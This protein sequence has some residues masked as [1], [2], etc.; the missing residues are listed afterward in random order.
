LSSL[1]KELSNLR[2]KT[3]LLEERCKTA[4]NIITTLSNLLREIEDNTDKRL[5]IVERKVVALVSEDRRIV[6]MLELTNLNAF[7]KLVIQLSALYDEI[8]Q[9]KQVLILPQHLY[10]IAIESPDRLITTLEEALR[11][12][13]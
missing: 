3:S 1:S 8:K 6:H 13:D 11:E 10:D 4:S 12:F 2:S 7:G 9:S 5:D